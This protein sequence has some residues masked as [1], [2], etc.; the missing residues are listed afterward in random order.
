VRRPLIAVALLVYL[1]LLVRY[2]C[3]AAGGSDSSGYL[4]AARVISRR[5]LK[6]RVAPLDTLHLD[7][8][9]RA[10]FVPLG[11][12]RAPE[13]KTMSPLYP[14][15]YPMHLVPFG[16]AG[17]WKHAPY[18]V[19][20]IMAV[21]CLMLTYSIGREL[22][23]P[24][25]HALAAAALLAVAPSFVYQ[26]LQPMSD[27][28]ATMWCLGA[29]RCSLL[30]AR[31]SEGRKTSNEQQTPINDQRSTSN[32]QR[33]AIFAGLAFAIA[34]WVRPS[35]LLLA[36]AIGFAMRWRVRALA[37]AVAASLPLAV[38]LWAVNHAL[39]GSALLT[40]YGSVDTL[41]WWTF[42]LERAPHYAKWLAVTETPLVFPGALFV[43]FN[44]RVAGWQRAL[45]S[46]WFVAFFAF[47]SFYG[48]YD[49]WW[50]LRFLLPALPAL[51]IGALLL[52]RD[53][54]PRR[55]VAAA[56]VAIVFV[57]GIAV[58]RHFPV[59]QM[60]EQEITYP[61]AVHW[62]EKLLPRDALVVSFQ[63]SGSFYFYANRFTARY[64]IVQP[65]EFQQLRAYAGMAGLKWYAVVYDWEVEPMTKNLP[66][67]WT[68]VGT[69][70]NI[71]L[72]RLDS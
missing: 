18:Y 57:T 14:L 49:A 38:A 10:A 47:Y 62:A 3:F 50:Y 20:P 41:V 28:T 53:F 52:A 64:D 34:V 31:C 55:A 12:A 46:V 6:V 33:A 42:P 9:W 58:I 25:A 7:D 43:V 65:D 26:A 44:R 15:G 59:L 5:Q 24:D 71:V 61:H 39:Y 22:G 30:V 72:L 17:G 51:L 35:N 4:N 70:R 36:P 63:L 54:V 66:G 67:K 45:L 60:H 2:T 1:A 69:M 56:L 48:A 11:F 21:L 16:M 23:L 13:P 40:G 68:T 37:T 8:R 32:D 29:I 19:T 27:V